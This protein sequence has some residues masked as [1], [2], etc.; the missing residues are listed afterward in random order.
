MF[1]NKS[2]TKTLMLAT[3]EYSEL[4]REIKRRGLELRRGNGRDDALLE[5]LT[6]RLG[7]PDDQ[8]QEFLDASLLTGEEFLSATYPA[9]GH[10]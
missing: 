10:G 1:D 4:Y 5:A 2:R 9:D 3:D 7:C 8:L 6:K